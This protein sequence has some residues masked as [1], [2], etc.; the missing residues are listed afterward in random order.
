MHVNDCGPEL[1]RHYVINVQLC[2]ESKGLHH[3]IFI[4][5][6]VCNAVHMTRLN[7][8]NEYLS[9]NNDDRQF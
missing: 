3:C 2:I 1:A 4:V 6:W 5:M 9:E 7:R 8:W